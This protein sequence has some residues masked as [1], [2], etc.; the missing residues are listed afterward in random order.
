MD[1]N[2]LLYLIVSMYITITI[3][4][5]NICVCVLWKGSAGRLK[6]KIVTTGELW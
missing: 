4:Y 1:Y 3:I 2:I 6:K 5:Y